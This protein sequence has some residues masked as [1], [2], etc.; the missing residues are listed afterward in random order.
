MQI[1]VQKVRY[2]IYIMS[3]LDY[4]ITGS[5]LRINQNVGHLW[6]ISLNISFI[7]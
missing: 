6:F 3:F 2:E 1:D 5:M 7:N 4:E